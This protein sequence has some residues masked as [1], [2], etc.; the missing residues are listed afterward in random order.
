MIMCKDYR[1]PVLGSKSKNETPTILLDRYSYRSYVGIVKIDETQGIMVCRKGLGR[2]QTP[3]TCLIIY[4][5]YKRI[6]G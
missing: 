5:R 2:L 3:S 6:K 4:F 1:S